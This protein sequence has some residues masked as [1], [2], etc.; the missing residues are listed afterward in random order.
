MVIQMKIWAGGEMEATTKCA[1]EELPRFGA[2]V[3][4]GGAV[5]K[6]WRQKNKAACR[7]DSCPVHNR[8]L[9]IRNIIPAS[10]DAA[11]QAG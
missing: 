4:N 2:M 10:S 1:F 6:H 3:Q 7:F 9:I 11:R 5:R 8:Q